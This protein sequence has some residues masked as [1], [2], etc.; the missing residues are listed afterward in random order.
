MWFL[1]WYAWLIFLHSSLPSSVLTPM[2]G[3]QKGNLVCQRHALTGLFWTTQPSLAQFS[4]N[5][6]SETKKNSVILPHFFYPVPYLQCTYAVGWRLERETN[7]P[8]RQSYCSSI[9]QKFFRRPLAANPVK[10]ANVVKMVDR[11][12]ESLTSSTTWMMMMMMM[13]M[14]HNNNK[15]N[16]V[17]T[18]HRDWA[19]SDERRKWSVRWRLRQWSALGC[20]ERSPTLWLPV[21]HTGTEYHTPPPA[22][23]DPCTPPR[24]EIPQL[25]CVPDQNRQRQSEIKD[26]SKRYHTPSSRPTS[27]TNLAHHRLPSTIRTDSTDFMTGPFLLSNLSY[28]L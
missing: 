18:V 8:T 27:L 10:P 11:T 20:A 17:A 3:Q 21:L 24:R 26:K 9:H 13:I 1:L 25:S 4:K 12:L 5:K 2:V 16:A 28:R 15:T 19:E 7:Q 14:K 6:P 22:A 23:T